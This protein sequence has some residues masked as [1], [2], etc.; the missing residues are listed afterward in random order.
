ME[1]LRDLLLGAVAAFYLAVVG[2]KLI[3]AIRL[4][5]A[6]KRGKTVICSAEITDIKLRR[7]TSVKS[8]EA[9]YSIG[10]RKITGQMVGMFNGKISIGQTLSVIVS[11]D[12]PEVFAL[13]ENH[14]RQ[15]AA[16]YAVLAA[17]PVL[18]FGVIVLVVTLV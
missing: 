6:V 15:A 10:E 17:M 13:G 16:V 9:Q 12:C 11:P 8:A 7:L 14:P 4:A 1:I 3:R 18:F 5:L 2:V